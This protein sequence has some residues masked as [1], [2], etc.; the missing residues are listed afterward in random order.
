MDEFRYFFDGDSHVSSYYIRHAILP[1]VLPQKY[2]PK[3]GNEYENYCYKNCV[4]QAEYVRGKKGGQYYIL[5]QVRT[6]LIQY[7]LVY[8]WGLFH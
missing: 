2:F 6:L 3:I 7:N 5:V 4:L 1:S 8:K